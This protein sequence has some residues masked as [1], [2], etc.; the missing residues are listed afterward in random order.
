MK[1][2]LLVS[3]LAFI[4]HDPDLTAQ[5]TNDFYQVETLQTPEGIASEV[6]AITFTRDGRLAACFRRGTTAR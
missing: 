4:L 1:Q 6:S 2:L 5:M 3:C